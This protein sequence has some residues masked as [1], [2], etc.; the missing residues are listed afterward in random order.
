M[1]RFPLTR[2]LLTLLMVAIFRAFTIFA[3]EPEIRTP[4]PPP[5]PHINGP[6]IFGIRPGA[7]FLYRIPTSGDRPIQFDVSSLPLDLQLDPKTGEI[8]GSLKKTGD[9]KVT[10]RA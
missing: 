3:A 6:S 5:R 9:Y 2:A 7:P 8:S 4:K 10:L 1:K